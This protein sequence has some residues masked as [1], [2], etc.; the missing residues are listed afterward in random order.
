MCGLNPIDSFGCCSTCRDDVQFKSVFDLRFTKMN[1]TRC[2]CVDEFKF[3][4]KFILREKHRKNCGKIVVAVQWTRPNVDLDFILFH[5]L[6]SDRNASSIFRATAND[7][8]MQIELAGEWWGAASPGF[9]CLLNWNRSN[10]YTKSWMRAT[11]VNEKVFCVDCGR[12][13]RWPVRAFLIYWFQPRNKIN[14]SH[15]KRAIEHPKC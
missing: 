10:S 4:V 7:F 3:L 9:V 11:H 6:S 14:D 13:E 15:S 5:C 1:E 8:G 2:R 12:G